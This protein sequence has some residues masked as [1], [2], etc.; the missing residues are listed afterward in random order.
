[1]VRDEDGDRHGFG[2]QMGWTECGVD[3]IGMDG[4]CFFVTLAIASMLCAVSEAESHK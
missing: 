4:T 1:M 3:R 2:N